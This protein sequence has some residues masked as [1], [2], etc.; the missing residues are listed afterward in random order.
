M[1]SC[2]SNLRTN[3][4]ARRDVVLIW[5]CKLRV[6]KGFWLGHPWIDAFP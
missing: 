5:K 1:P 4:P 2:F 6:L 3:G